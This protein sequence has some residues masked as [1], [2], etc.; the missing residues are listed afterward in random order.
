MTGGTGG[1]VWT[2]GANYS[3]GTA[4][5]SSSNDINFGV[6]GTA[7]T[8][9]FS[10]AA[11]T[12][13]VKDMLFGTTSSTI[14]TSESVTLSGTGTAG[15]T[16]ISLAGNVT[17][18]SPS[19]SKAIIGSDI[20][21]NLSNAAHAVQFAANPNVSGT[22]A[23][24]G[25]LV[26]KSLV[27]GGGASSTISTVFSN[28]GPSNSN[29][30]AMVLSNDAN[31]FDSKITG[32]SR[33]YYTSI[34]N[35]GEVS[36]LGASTGANSVIGM[37]GG[38]IFSYIGATS[39]TSNRAITVS[40]GTPLIANMAASTG[41]TL[42]L[43]GTLSFTGTS[44]LRLG[45]TAGNSLVIDTVIANGTGFTTG[46]TLMSGA[47]RYDANGVYS[48]ANLTGTTY[49][50]G[51]NTYT[52]VTT[53]WGGFA[54]IERFGNINEASGLGKGSWQARQQT[55]FLPE[56]V[57][58]TLRRT[59]HRRIASLRFQTSAQELRLRLIRRRQIPPIR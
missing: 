54:N 20:T 1:T 53:L 2:S 37:G 56:E 36:S 16:T 34:G 46:V 4:T 10:G 26:L 43:N 38:G 48:S 49:L 12:Y 39:Q 42:T 7:G 51:L 17:L 41:T 57:S 18:P 30:P 15:Q 31:T 14:S 13:A 25:V 55:L 3:G 58:S 59:P 8:Y 5:F 50:K 52:G 22:L 24:P 9:S 23:Q 28:Y 6:I 33:I 44:T 45:A 35:V 21:L 11:G 40:G 29:T 27:T 32:S 47:D 19:G